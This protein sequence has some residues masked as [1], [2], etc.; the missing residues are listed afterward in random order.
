[1]NSEQRATRAFWFIATICICILA[2]GLHGV[3][4]DIQELK[5]QYTFA[6][7][8]RSYP[9]NQIENI[10]DRL[11]ILEEAMWLEGYEHTREESMPHMN[12]R[13]LLK[14]FNYMLMNTAK[15]HELESVVFFPYVSQSGKDAPYVEDCGS[16][17]VLMVAKFY[18]VAG[19]ETVLW[20]HDNL[21]GGDYVT[22]YVH[23]ATYLNE[24]Y[25]LSTDIIATHPAVKE[26]LVEQ[27]YPGAEDITVIDP[28]EFPNDVPVVWIYSRVPHWIVR[29]KGWAYDPMLGI[30]RFEAT[31]D[32][33]RPDYG[34]GIIVIKEE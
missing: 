6:L 8:S 1:M 23:L 26:D 11:D 18:D 15:I 12:N 7:D 14:D 33:Y 29:Y 30:I 4:K 16:A 24:W 21:I 22:N 27:K 32:I 17:A 9:G 3:Q 13:L 28:S 25:G 20:T 31:E 5:N 10:T 34:L 19:D 2:F